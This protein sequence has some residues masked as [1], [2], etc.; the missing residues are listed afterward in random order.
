MRWLTAVFD[1]EVI[2]SGLIKNNSL[3][4]QDFE[5]QVYLQRIMIHVFLKTT[6]SRI[7]V[8]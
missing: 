6:T 1:S 3:L 8:F 2:T 5:T 4:A 7:T